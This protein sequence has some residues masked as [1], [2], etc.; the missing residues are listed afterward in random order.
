MPL[1]YT[2]L[3]RAYQLRFFLLQLTRTSGSFVVTLRVDGRFDNQRTKT[4]LRIATRYL[5]SRIHSGLLFRMKS[6]KVVFLILIQLAGNSKYQ[7]RSSY[8]AKWN[9]TLFAGKRQRSRSHL[10]PPRLLIP[11]RNNSPM[12]N[13]GALRKGKWVLRY[14]L[15]SKKSTKVHMHWVRELVTYTKRKSPRAVVLQD[16]Y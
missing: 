6:S 9:H 12:W 4:S 7:E 11:G 16:I 2:T 14:I 5:A 3:Q 10:V 13:K 8:C 15:P 1:L